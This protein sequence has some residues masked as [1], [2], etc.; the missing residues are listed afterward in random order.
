M[1]AEAPLAGRTV[2][3]IHPAWHSCGTATVVASQA[4]AYRALGARVLSAALSDHPFF[5]LSQES[6]ARA[7]LRAT[8]E[9]VAD[10]R[11]VTGIG[12]EAALN[13][14]K[15]A[16]IGWNFAHGNF[17]ATYI[18]LAE[19]S[20]V[21][22][23][24]ATERIHLIHANHFFTM[25]LAERLRAAQ[26]CPLL[27]D[28]HDVQARQYMLRNERGW[29]LPPRAAYE[30]MLKTELA[31]LQRADRLLHLN[32]EEEAAFRTL[33]PGSLHT[34]VYPAVDPMPTGPGGGD[35]VIVASANVPNILSLEWFL[36]EVVPRA[37]DVPL[38]IYGN[39]DAAIRS[40]DPALYQRHSGYFRG[41][42]ED[43]GA[44]Y[45][46]AACVLLPTIEGHGLSIKTI[47]ALSSGAAL[48]ATRHAFRGIDIDPASLTNVTIAE[49][50]AA[51]A[52]ALWRQVAERP[53]L[54]A[55]S[56]SPTRQLYDALFSPRAYRERLGG[57]VAP[58]LGSE[59]GSLP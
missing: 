38:A 6:L 44:A 57:L 46:A 32:S 29:Y 12:T 41:R 21:P 52:E 37:G 25:P 43:L 51:F 28:S 7:Y 18:A 30:T 35:F 55:G 26:G 56:A 49:D 58:L 36:R 5:G 8:P 34:L 4:R 14:L 31:W 17:A 1:A 15:I 27:L 11:L 45:S 13:P 39:V 23:E 42:V 3:L 48:I 50:A 19:N 53:D 47:E 20:A 22:A 10:R 33:L 59:I 2:A 9:L 24:L 54:A 40:R 16:P